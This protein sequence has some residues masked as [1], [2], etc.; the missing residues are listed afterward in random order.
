M[1]RLV[2]AIAIA[3]GGFMATA[4]Q[5]QVMPHIGTIT[6]LGAKFCPRGWLQAD[7]Q[8]LIIVEHEALFNVIGTTYGGDGVETFALPKLTGGS[9]GPVKPPLTWCIA[10]EGIAPAHMPPKH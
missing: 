7:G 10:N 5:A 6:A 2:L 9:F 3:T 4:A 1:H 8:V